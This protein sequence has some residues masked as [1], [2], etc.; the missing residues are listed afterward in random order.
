MDE[1]LA[2][3]TAAVSGVTDRQEMQRAIG[4]LALATPTVPESERLAAVAPG[5]PC[6]P[7]RTG[8]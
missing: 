5:C 1:L 7:G 6:R 8:P 4:G 3:F 2:R